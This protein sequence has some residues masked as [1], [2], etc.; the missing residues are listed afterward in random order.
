MVDLPSSTWIPALLLFGAAAFGT[1]GL[2]LVWE[3]VRDWWEQRMVR[4]HLDTLLLSVGGPQAMDAEQRAN[5]LR[6]PKAGSAEEGWGAAFRGLPGM[7]TVVALL[8]E[9]HV[10]WSPLTFYLLTF[11]SAAAMGGVALT[12]SGSLLISSPIAA[13]GASLPYLYLRRRRRLVA[14][15]FEREFPEALDLLTRAIRAGHPLT[16]G[17]SMVGEEGPAHAAAEFRKSFDEHRFGLPFDDALLGMVDRV[18]LVD[19]RIFATA[20]LIQRESGGNLA[21]ILEKLGQTIRDRFTIRRQLRVYTAQGRMSGYTLAA[22]PVVVGTLIYL[23]EPEYVSL[24][25]TETIGR[26]L[27]VAAL[28]MQFMGYLWIR[29]IVN[30]EI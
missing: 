16:A 22:L 26:L 13:G 29:K 27:L 28:V 10:R 3:V 8:E 1:L 14:E 4:R 24:L 20:V 11:G 6:R 7:P 18:G 2:V 17:L 25:F 19:V 23:I 12:V 15:A 30:I 21:E 5:L 9:A